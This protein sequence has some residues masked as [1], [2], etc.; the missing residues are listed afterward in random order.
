MAEIEKLD[1]DERYY[2]R[3]DAQL[4]MFAGWKP[5]FEKA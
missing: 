2:H 3:T 1:K 5:T 4:D